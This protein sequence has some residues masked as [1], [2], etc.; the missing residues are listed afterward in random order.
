MPPAADGAGRHVLIDALRGCALLGVFLVNLRAISLYDFLDEAGRAALPTARFDAAADAAMGLLV[1]VKAITVFSLLFGVGFALQMARIGDDDAAGV[2]RYLR[3]LAVLAAIG[4]LHAVFVWW[5]DILLTYA[6]VGVALLAFRH[7]SPRTLL[8]AGVVCAILLPPLLSP[9]MRDWLAHVPKQADAYA[10]AY[11]GFASPS[12]VDAFR[13]NVDLALWARTANWALVGFVLGRFLL[14]DWAGR[15]GL[16]QAPD[17]HRARLQWIC[18]V[19]FAIALAALWLSSVQADLRVRWPLLDTATGKYAIRAALRLEPLAGGIAFA[20]GFALLY[21]RL[22]WRN[23][24]SVFAP[25]G[26]M[27]LTHYLLQSVVCVPVF[28]GFGLG[29]G[30]RFGMVAVLAGGIGVFAL[31][32]VASRW[33]LRRYR[34]G[35]VEWGWRA[36]TY[37]ARPPF[38]VEARRS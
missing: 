6:V 24:L 21:L 31:Q 3:R 17:A 27:A 15:T 19:A 36:L 34:F 9:W 37:G 2:R 35:P 38:R 28:Y 22:A 12:I 4:L 1:D 11:A 29:V 33:W 13:A 20:S 18:G 8:A 10:A 23:L 16:L 14:G 7:A 32:V 5:G 30:P 26:R 25:V